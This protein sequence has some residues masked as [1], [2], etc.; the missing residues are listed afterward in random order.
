MTSTHSL[1]GAHRRLAA[2]L[3]A[4]T[5]LVV[6]LIVILTGGSH[7]PTPITH[8]LLRKAVQ[9]AEADTGGYDY[10]CQIYGAPRQLL[11]QGQGNSVAFLVSANGQLQPEP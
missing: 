11:C 6:V 9:A 4:T 5:L 10:S 8:K 2:G 7:G 3:I 1:L